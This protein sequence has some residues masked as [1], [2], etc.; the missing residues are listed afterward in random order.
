MRQES[1]NLHGSNILALHVLSFTP[2]LSLSNAAHLP[3]SCSTVPPICY[4]GNWF[5]YNLIP[6]GCISGGKT[7][8]GSTGAM[9]CWGWNA[10]PQTMPPAP[11]A[12]AQPAP[13]TWHASY[14]P[15][16]CGPDVPF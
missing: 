12:C 10:W 1:H 16:L 8:E 9:S 7:Y 6:S 13:V 2:S 11:G 5:G 14:P 15:F 3:A 4:S